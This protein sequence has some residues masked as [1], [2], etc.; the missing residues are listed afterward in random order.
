[1][2]CIV[3]EVEQLVN[4][5]IADPGEVLCWRSMRHKNIYSNLLSA[6]LQGNILSMTFKNVQYHISSNVN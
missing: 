3:W 5:F 4:P 2:P 6:Y 1:M